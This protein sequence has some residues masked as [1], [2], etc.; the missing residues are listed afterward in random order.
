MLLRF[1]LLFACS[2][3]AI[4]LI[5]YFYSTIVMFTAAAMLAAL[6]NYP[7]GW[8][9][10][11]IPRGAAVA[12]VFLSS[13]FLLV[14]LVFFL[15]LEALNQGQGLVAQIS[16]ALQ[17]QE[18]LPL[19]DLL[20]KINFERIIETLRTSLVSGL[21][22]VSTIFSSVF[23]LVFLA[24]ISLYM[25]IDGENLW[26]MALRLIPRQHRDRL[27]ATLQHTFLTFIRGQVSLMLIL[28]G[29]SFIVFS[30]LGI[31]YAL[32]LA[33]IIGILDA[34]PGIGATLG[35]LT[36]ALLILASQGWMV[37][38]QAVIASVLLQQLQDN[39]IQP[40]LMG[41]ELEINP[42]ILFLAL[43]IGERIAGLLGVFL[44]IPIAGV[45]AAYLKMEEPEPDSAAPSHTPPGNG[46]QAG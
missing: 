25:L 11:Y 5:Q 29:L 14:S 9:S 35:V 8:L 16:T 44:A 45:I 40:K 36:T 19:Q 43:F 24:V 4:V 6:L 46:N 26:K 1:L 3:A 18:L 41:G 20:T 17:N 30:F 15:G 39:F 12:I 31:K 33:L 22:L 34:I 37:A 23:S 32:I 21:G 27:G 28:S 2:W 10:R 38:L 7:V 13:L 42:V